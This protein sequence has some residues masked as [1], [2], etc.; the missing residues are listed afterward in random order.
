MKFYDDLLTYC[1]ALREEGKSIIICGD[2][3]TA[4]KGIDLKN[5][6]ANSKKSGL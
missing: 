2:V 4:H 5:P 3:N 6:K 1:E